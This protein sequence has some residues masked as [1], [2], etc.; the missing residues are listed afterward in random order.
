MGHS[1][2]LGEGDPMTQLEAVQAGF[3]SHVERG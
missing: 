2:D 3:R 1:R